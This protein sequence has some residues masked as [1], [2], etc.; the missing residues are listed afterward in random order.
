M[1][2][3][4]P[5]I[6]ARFFD[7]ITTPPVS[8]TNGPKRLASK[9]SARPAATPKISPNTAIRAGHDSNAT[10]SFRDSTFAVI[11]KGIKPRETS[12]DGRFGKCKCGS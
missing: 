5:V 3:D 10:V 12:L 2:L 6:N 7:M 9:M 4:A 1:P 8:F 11:R